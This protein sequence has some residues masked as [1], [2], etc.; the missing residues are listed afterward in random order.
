[1]AVRDRA[2]AAS[3]ADHSWQRFSAWPKPG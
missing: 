1:V 2:A 3:A